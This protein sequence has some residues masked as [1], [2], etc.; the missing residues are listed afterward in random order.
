MSLDDLRR[1]TR[2]EFLALPRLGVITLERCERLLAREL[3]AGEPGPV[4]VVRAPDWGS[5][6]SYKQWRSLG[7]TPSQVKLFL[8]LS[9]TLEGINTWTGTDMLA[10]PGFDAGTLVLLEKLLGR[11][12][13]LPAG[14]RHWLE[15][16]LSLKAGRALVAA[17]FLTLEDL[18]GR[19]R[20]EILRTG[21]GTSN[22]KKL[23]TLTGLIAFTKIFRED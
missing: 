22:L 17:N 12:V 19:S 5:V 2:K 11:R 3:P 9:A 13:M 1:L 6:L 20:R 23:E 10:I 14:L 18:V 7:F 16:G 21:I 15:A 8:K 4:T